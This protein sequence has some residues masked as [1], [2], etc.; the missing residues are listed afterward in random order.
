M[1]P[2][3]VA[4]QMP[5]KNHRV[6]DGQLDQVLRGVR[7]YGRSGRRAYIRLVAH[8]AVRTRVYTHEVVRST[9]VGSECRRAH[10]TSQ[11]A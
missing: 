9:L 3:S 8:R 4:Q 10:S 1:D 5:H 6:L 7:N 11:D 2:A